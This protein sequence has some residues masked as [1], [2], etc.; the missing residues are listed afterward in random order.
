MNKADQRDFD[1]HYE[2]WDKIKGGEMRRMETKITCDFC[3]HAI[4][5]GE[6]WLLKCPDRY[7]GIDY[8][9]CVDCV[10]IIKFVIFKKGNET[11]L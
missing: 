9:V 1:S 10:D 4:I 3:E 11:F 8:D 2:Y 5:N 6:A 7:R